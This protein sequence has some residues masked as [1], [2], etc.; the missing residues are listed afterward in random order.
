VICPQC[1]N[2]VEITESQFLSMF[3][4]PRCMAVYFI[5]ILG[6]PEFGDMPEAPLP[7][8]MQA[9]PVSD[10]STNLSD[11]LSGELSN[12]ISAEISAE[13]SSELPSEDLLSSDDFSEDL[14]SGAN[15]F[16]TVNQVDQT[17]A[18]DDAASEIMGFANQDGSVSALSYNLKVTG[19]DTKD[20]MALFKEA[21]NDS[22]FGW[23]PQ[24]VFSKIKNG[25]C[26][27]TELNPVQ[28]FV[29]AKRIQFL[30]IEMH[31]TQNV[32]I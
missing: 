3:T 9:E 26:E 25:E 28:A 23:L 10:I 15:P 1:A 24:D 19:L 22:K 7:E 13:I 6:Q 18:F 8:A 2:E 21:L 32:Q 16:D 11:E 20:T 27:L 5:D 4:C 31:W 17:S 29:L 14:N 30:D 12:E